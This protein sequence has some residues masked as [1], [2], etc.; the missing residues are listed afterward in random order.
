MLIMNFKKIVY[1]FGFLLAVLV[2]LQIGRNTHALELSNRTLAIKTSIGGATTQHTLSFNFESPETIG[3][4]VLQYCTSP[5]EDIACTPPAGLDASQAVLSA[6]SGETGFTI[7]SQTANVLILT[8]TPSITGLQLNSY[9]FDNVV[10]PSNKGPFFMRVNTYASDDGSGPKTDFGGTA[11]SIT[12]SVSITAE[13]PPILQFCVGITIQ[14]F[15]TIVDGTF[16]DLGVLTSTRAAVG[17]SRFQAYT[18]AEFGYSVRV[19][20]ATITSGN[21]VIDALASPTASSPGVRQFGINLRANTQPA[22][23]ADPISGNGVIDPNY[24]VP[25]FY[26][27]N[28]GDVLVTNPGIGDFETY[29]VTYLV[30]IRNNQTP[31]IYNTILTYFCTANF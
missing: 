20:G 3:S 7:L 21:N 26:T 17:T 29:T 24:A 15:C 10:N 12:Q 5:V 23:G 11:G 2:L 25:N 8:R 28:D 30:N 31:G 6:Q 9:T 14:G 1:S 18:N 27:Y 13:V 22:V 16:L 19:T 4:L